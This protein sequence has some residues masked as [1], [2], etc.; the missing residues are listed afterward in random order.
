MITRNEKVKLFLIPSPHPTYMHH[1]LIINTITITAI[2][3]T[4]HHIINTITTITTS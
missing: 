4:I 1:H 2:T 3:L